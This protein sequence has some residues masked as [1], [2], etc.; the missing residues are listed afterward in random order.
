MYDSLIRFLKAQEN[1]YTQVLNE[2]RAGIKRTHWI[3]YIFPQLKGLG[4]SNNSIYYGL[5]NI[6]EARAY[7]AHP[8]L[9]SR[10]RNICEVLLTHK[11]KSII[12]ILG[13]I[14]T[15]KV[16]SSMTLFHAVSPDDVFKVVLIQFYDGKVDSKTWNMLNSTK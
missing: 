6:E 9:G 2:M 7:L 5:D 16:R 12:E 11:E 8:I 3:W 15:M 4:T 10:L 13:D 14:D 1:T